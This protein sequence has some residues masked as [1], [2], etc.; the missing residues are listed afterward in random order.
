MR[1]LMEHLDCSATFFLQFYYPFRCFY[2]FY[3]DIF[4]KARVSNI[5]HL[6]F[7]YER[8]EE[9]KCRENLYWRTKKKRKI[10]QKVCKP[11]FRKNWINVASYRCKLKSISSSSINF[12]RNIKKRS[13]HYHYHILLLSVNLFTYCVC[14]FQPVKSPCELQDF[15]FFSLFNDLLTL[16]TETE[17][18]FKSSERYSFWN[19]NDKFQLVYWCVC[20]L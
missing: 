14:N 7:V 2:Y 20:V 4:N 5:K 10:K 8:K 16:F 17:E 18:R 13:K 1:W 9:K 6:L 12:K 3:V 15:F 19:A 11:L